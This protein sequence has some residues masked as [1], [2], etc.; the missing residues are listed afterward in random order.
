MDQHLQN[1][2]RNEASMYITFYNQVASPE[3]GKNPTL[4]K[5]LNKFALPN[6]GPWRWGGW[7]WFTYELLAVVLSIR[8]G[9]SSQYETTVPRDGKKTLYTVHVAQIFNKASHE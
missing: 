8:W 7:D 9:P 2:A 5:T 3:I 6:V 4:H 1:E